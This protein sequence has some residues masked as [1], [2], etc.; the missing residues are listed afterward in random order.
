MAPLSK[1]RLH[2]QILFL[3]KVA[4]APGDAGIRKDV[5]MKASLRPR[6]GSAVRRIGR[7]RQ[8]WTTEFV[9]I[10]TDSY[11]GLARASGAE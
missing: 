8:D 1:Q 3:G 9:K 2:K 11:G 4:R 10:A 5:F 6:V 7:P